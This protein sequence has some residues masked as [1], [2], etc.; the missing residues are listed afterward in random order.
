MSLR[1][2]LCLSV[3]VLLVAFSASMAAPSQQGTN[4]PVIGPRWEYKMLRLDGPSCLSE[5]LVTAPLNALGQQ[6]WEL[7]TYER[8]LPPFPK[9]AEGTLL[10]RPAATGPSRDVVPQTADSFQGTISMRMGQAQQQSVGCNM[11]LKRQIY[12]PGR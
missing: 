5:T 10:I 1:L 2:P 3:L 4:N 6:G 11:L 8:P 7:V 12:P 9:D